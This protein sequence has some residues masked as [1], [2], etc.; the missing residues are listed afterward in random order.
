MKLLDYRCKE[1]AEEVIEYSMKK[2]KQ[3]RE[4]ERNE[5]TYPGA[6]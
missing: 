1:E 4:R 5:H 6:R 3:G 2:F